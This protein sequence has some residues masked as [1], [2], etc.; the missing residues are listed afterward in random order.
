MGATTG[1]DNT[2]LAIAVKVFDIGAGPISAVIAGLDW[3]KYSY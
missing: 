3:G 2:T 1:V